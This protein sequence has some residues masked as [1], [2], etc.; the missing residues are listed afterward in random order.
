[1]LAGIAGG[2]RW[3]M[4]TTRRTCLVVVFDVGTGEAKA[5]G[6][7]LWMVVLLWEVDRRKESLKEALQEGGT[8]LDAFR[9]GSILP[10]RPVNCG[11][12]RRWE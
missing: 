5:L 1:M 2:A 7:R 12:R 8:R 4:A 9:N 3:M 11:G 10:C 6:T